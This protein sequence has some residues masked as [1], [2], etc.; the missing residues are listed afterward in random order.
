MANY[1]LVSSHISSLCSTPASTV[2]VETAQQNAPLP[3][4]M[5]DND[6]PIDHATCS[7]VLTTPQAG[8]ILLRVIHGGLIAELMSLSTLVPSIRLVFPA[9]VLP[10]PSLFLWEDSELHLLLVTE[11]GSLYRIAIPI[12]GLN[13]WQGQIK[14]IWPREYSIR[15]L[16]VEQVK[17]CMV[18]VQG[19]H[20]V[21]VSLPNGVLLRLEAESLG[22]DGNEGALIFFVTEVWAS[23]H[24]STP[25]KRMD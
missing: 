17:E 12:D 8:T 19:T 21:A 3:S 20:C 24:I 7:F 18:H 14:N 23:T 9:A 13:L 4:G 11:I 25:G 2:V 6:L 16:P 10:T 5:Q 15:N 22:Y 1:F